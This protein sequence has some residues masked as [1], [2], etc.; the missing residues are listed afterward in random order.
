MTLHTYGMGAL[1]PH[2]LAIGLSFAGVQI[3][4][5]ELGKGPPTGGQ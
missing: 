1:V 3:G 4:P 5:G 2:D